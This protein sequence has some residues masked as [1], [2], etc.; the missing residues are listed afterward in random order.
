MCNE[1]LKFGSLLGRARKL[2]AEKIA[3]GHY[4][5]T[6][7]DPVTG[8]TVLLATKIDPSIIGGVIAQIGS[9]ARSC[10]RRCSKNSR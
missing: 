3:T 2:G 5:R 8:R 7:P 6:E 9:T 4:A 10:H 1:K